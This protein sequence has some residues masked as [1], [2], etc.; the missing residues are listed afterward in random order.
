MERAVEAALPNPPSMELVLLL[1]EILTGFV[2]AQMLTTN[3]SSA[4]SASHGV[5][6]VK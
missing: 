1:L 3:L 4:T 6:C 2:T 5:I